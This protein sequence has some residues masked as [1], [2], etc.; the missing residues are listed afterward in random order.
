MK[1]KAK[2]V[3]FV[4]FAAIFIAGCAA[5]KQSGPM[6]VLDA[7]KVISDLKRAQGSPANVDPTPPSTMVDV[8]E[9]V[10]NDDIAR[11]EAAWQ[12]AAGKEGLDALS[13]R[14]ALQLS[15]ASAQTGIANYLNE[16]AVQHSEEASL[17]TKRKD[18]GYKLSDSEK[19]RLKKLNTEAKELNQ[20]LEALRVL[21][22]THLQAGKDLADEIIRQFPDK[23][24][25]YKAKANFHRLRDEWTLFTEAMNMAGRRG[26][27]DNP[28]MLYLSA[29]EQIQ[30]FDLRNEGVAMLMELRQMAPDYVRVQAS[31]VLTQADIEYT[32]EEL[33]KLK[34]VSP[35]HPLVLI[36]GPII[37]E[38]YQDAMALRQAR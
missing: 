13:I 36:A 5:P 14:A 9:I 17:I 24:D 10:K 25:G 8:F 7:Q 1:N 35:N 34:A 23:P 19:T 2:A 33:V 16:L 20:V 32:Y 29:M 3:L 31:L 38:Q 37:E 26:P 11:F 6:S 12:F 27:A 22:K 28:G 4:A 15:W 18:E 21:S 30:R